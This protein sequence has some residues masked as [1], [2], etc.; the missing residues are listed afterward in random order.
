MKARVGRLWR[1]LRR[2]DTARSR[3][4]GR[5]AAMGFDLNH[6]ESV[7]ALAALDPIGRQVCLEALPLEQ[8][9]RLAASDDFRAEYGVGLDDLSDGQLERLATGE[10]PRAVVGSHERADNEQRST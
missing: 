2:R 7:A 1:D 10:D 6:P 4:Q 3:A 5:A 9:E 8:L